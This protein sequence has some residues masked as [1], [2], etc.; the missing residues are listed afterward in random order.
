[1]NEDYLQD[2]ALLIAELEDEDDAC[3]SFGK[4]LEHLLE[5]SIRAER[6]EAFAPVVRLC[7]LLKHY[8]INN[9]ERRWFEKMT[10]ELFTTEE[11]Q[12]IGSDDEE[13]SG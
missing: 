3:G 11:L 10:D 13:L 6:N 9:Q 8:A 7:Q 12:Q 1:M 4:Y 2:L 5:E